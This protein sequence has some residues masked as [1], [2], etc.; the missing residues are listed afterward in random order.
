MSAEV[1]NFPQW[2]LYSA[3]F[4][5]E[6][7]IPY[8]IQADGD[9]LLT[10]RLYE[11]NLQISTEIWPLISHTEIALR[12]SLATRMGHIAAKRNYNKHWIF[13][14]QGLLG[15]LK[16]DPQRST[17]GNI[18]RA[19]NRISKN[20]AVSS[21]NKV[22]AEL[23]LGFWHNLTSKT[24]RNIWPD[25]VRAFPNAPTRDQEHI[26]KL[27]SNLASLRNRIAHHEK[28][29]NL[30]LEHLITQIVDLACYIDWELGYYLEPALLEIRKQVVEFNQ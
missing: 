12:N 1:N 27:I 19:K 23:N 21:P 11:W 15:S 4:T 13:D 20:G 26:F 6:R 25:L 5:S 16:N 9:F 29:W 24:H 18:I 8:L 7:L 10:M 17:Y 2:E 28:I 22:I 3:H 30:P 14:E